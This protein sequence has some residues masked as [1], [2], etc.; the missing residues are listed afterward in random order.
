MHAAVLYCLMQCEMH[1]AVHWRLGVD[2]CLALCAAFCLKTDGVSV[3]CLCCVWQYAKCPFLQPAHTCA[4]SMLRCWHCIQGW[5]CR[6]LV[7]VQLF[8]AEDSYLPLPTDRAWSRVSLLSCMCMHAGELLACTGVA[9]HADS[10]IHDLYF[11]LAVCLL[12]HSVCGS[13]RVDRFAAPY[14]DD[15]RS[16]LCVGLVLLR[17]QH[18]EKFDQAAAVSACLSRR[19]KACLSCKSV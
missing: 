5:H 15:A 1:A 13:C 8:K 3:S 12:V 7:H 18:M 14:C 11:Q 19:A 9:L 10:H 6:K 2:L 16:C 17:H 4:V